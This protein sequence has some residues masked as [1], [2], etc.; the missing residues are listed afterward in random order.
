MGEKLILYSTNTWLAFMIAQK[1]YKDEH[2]IWCT[3]VFDSRKSQ[4][5]GT[6][7]PPTSCPCEI[8]YNL[9]E[10]VSRGDRHSAKIKENRIGIFRGAE[11][12]FNQGVITAEQKAEIKAIVDQAETRDFRP[13]MYIMPYE[14]V[15][16]M[17]KEVP[18][19]DR[20]HPLSEEYVIDA[21]PRKDFDI[22]ELAA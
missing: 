15:K 20:A 6:M 19:G 2:Y 8:Y 22:I 14:R 4:Y 21:L 1:Y 13:L 5:N 7:V 3:P 16:S 18:I 9:H 10:E 12:K 11:I 17:A